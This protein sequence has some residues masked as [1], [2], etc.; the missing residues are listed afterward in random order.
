MHV[1]LQF[2]SAFSCLF[3]FSYQCSYHMYSPSLLQFQKQD[4]QIKHCV[5]CKDCFMDYLKVHMSMN[6]FILWSMTL[7]WG[8][9]CLDS[10]RL[11]PTGRPD[12]V[13]MNN[14][15]SSVSNLGSLPATE[16]LDCITSPISQWDLLLLGRRW[17]VDMA[18]HQPCYSI[19][20]HRS[21]QL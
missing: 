12:S 7:F 8:L 16:L 11:L 18:Q 17:H 13:V 19:S 6:V 3:Q 5:C 14:V 1:A 10:P 2:S 20:V 15:R 4:V 9:H 21:T